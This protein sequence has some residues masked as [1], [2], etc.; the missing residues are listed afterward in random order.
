MAFSRNKGVVAGG[1]EALDLRFEFGT[2]SGSGVEKCL[3]ACLFVVPL[4]RVGSKD[5]SE[6]CPK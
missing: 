5:V 2:P 1:L 4:K 3:P 6:G